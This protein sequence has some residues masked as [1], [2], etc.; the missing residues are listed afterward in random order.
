MPIFSTSCGLQ[1]CHGS[2]SA[3]QAG[4]YLGD[5]P[6]T[7]YENLVGVAAMTYPQMSRITAGDPAHSYLQFRIDNDACTLAGCTTIECSELMPQG[8]PE[9]AESDRL[10]IRGWIAQG[11]LND[12]PDAGSTDAGADSGSKTEDSG[13]TTDAS[14]TDAADS[15]PPEDAAPT[16]APSE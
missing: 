8:G 9:L 6:S 10:Q 16:D 14:D 12:L 11:A 2:T 4:L 3:P 1:S 13:S 5:D 15:A 7:V